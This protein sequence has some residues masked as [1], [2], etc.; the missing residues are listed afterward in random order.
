MLPNYLNVKKS[1]IYEKIHVKEIP[2]NKIGKF[3][4]FRKNEIDIWIRNPYASALAKSCNLDRKE[5]LE[6]EVISK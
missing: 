6:K 2:H 5:V 3:P 4:R 1:Y